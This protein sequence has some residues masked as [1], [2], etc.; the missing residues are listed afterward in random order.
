[1]CDNFSAVS[2]LFNF[3]DIRNLAML[4]IRG[5]SKECHT[6]QCLPTINVRFFSQGLDKG[7][8]RS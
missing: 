6:D 5:S 4:K 1:M 8:I 2:G 7:I 3:K